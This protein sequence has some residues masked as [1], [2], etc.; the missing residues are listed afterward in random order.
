MLIFVLNNKYKTDRL[1]VLLDGNNRA[2]VSITVSHIERNIEQKK[3]MDVNKLKNNS[4]SAL[5]SLLQGNSKIP[6]LVPPVL[7][8]VGKLAAGVAAVST[9]NNVGSATGKFDS[10]FLIFH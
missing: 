7:H 4:K 3:T 10:E 6:N 5:G 1:V 9:A 2:H 8:E